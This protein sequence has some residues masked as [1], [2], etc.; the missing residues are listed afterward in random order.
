MWSSHNGSDNADAAGVG[1]P[2]WRLFLAVVLSDSIRT[3]LAEAIA[4]LR[5]LA[6][7]ASP[8]GL[9]AIHLTLHF[10]GQV[11]SGRVSEIADGLKQAIAPFAAFEL[12]ASGVGAFPTPARPR[13]LWAGVAGPGHAGLVAIHEATTSPLRSAGIALEDRP[14]APHLTL[15]RVRRELRASERGRLEEWIHRWQAFEFGALM[16]DAIH[17]MRSDLSAR[18][19][20]YTTLETFALQ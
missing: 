16:V 6:P 14:Y 1:A 17:L 9:E 12:L 4:E 15:G 20:R 13:V 18:P 11:E 19:P 2:S 5:T 3:A 8:A 10:L 7:F